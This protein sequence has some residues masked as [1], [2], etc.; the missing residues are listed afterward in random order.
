MVMEFSFSYS[1]LLK[2][3][4]AFLGFVFSACSFYG[5]LPLMIMGNKVLSQLLRDCFLESMTYESLGL[6]ESRS[7]SF[8]Y[9]KTIELLR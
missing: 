8:L 9:I 3:A 7:I 4:G 2:Y 1:L 5:C 6:S